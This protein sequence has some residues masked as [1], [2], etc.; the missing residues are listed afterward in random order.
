MNLLITNPREIQSYVIL[1]CLR[2]CAQRIVVTEG[3]DA[4]SA[5][6]FEGMT[7][8]SRFVDARYTVPHFATAWLAG[9]LDDSISN[10][11]DEEAYIQRL[12]EICRLERIDVIFPSLDPEVYLLAK[13]KQR[14]A[15]QGVLVVVPDSEILRVPL[16]KGLTMKVATRVGFP[17]PYTFFPDSV[18]DL[19]HIIRDSQPP[20]IVKPRLSVH[21]YGMVVVKDAA[22]LRAAYEK[23]HSR[24]QAPIVQEYIEGDQRQNYYLTIDR[25]GRILT[26]LAPRVTRTHRWGSHRVAAKRAVSASDAPYAAEVR[27]LVKELGLWGGYTVQTKIDPRDG[28]PKLM[29]INARLGHHV[30]WRT[31]LGVNEPRIL[32]QVARGEKPTGKMQFPDGVLLLDP[33]FDLV[34][35]YPQVVSALATGARRLIGRGRRQSAAR[36]EH[37]TPG[38]MELLRLHARDYLNLQP[39]VFC[40]EV[41]SLLTDPY[42]CLKLYWSQ[43]RV[44]NAR[45]LER[46][47]RAFR[48]N[49]SP[50]T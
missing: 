5:G 14:F 29:E 11:E 34:E 6:G 17:C 4:I 18:D 13:N 36:D 22:E 40:P 28:K 30:W 27:S 45:Y 39:K 38:L 1:R 47:T 2:D 24:Q 26:M 7:A 49:G 41:S 9:R 33:N 43:L 15:D 20:W 3:G 25:D 32:L 50:A 37:A 8:F 12:E 48:R 44:L 23:V 31:G 35:L 21:G 10:S 46:L 42:P 19:A 16:D